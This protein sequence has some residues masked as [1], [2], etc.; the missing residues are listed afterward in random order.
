M[1]AQ[2]FAARLAKT[3]QEAKQVNA[4]LERL[5][6]ERSEAL[7]SGNAEK[8]VAS[9]RQAKALQERLEDLVITKTTL[10][11]KLRAYKQNEPEAAKLRDE[12]QAAWEE[13]RTMTAE[14]TKAQQNI[15]G[16]SFLQWEPCRVSIKI[17]VEAS[18][19]QREATYRNIRQCPGRL[20]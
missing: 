14:I 18:S 10:E 1:S 15:A 5:G 8:A 13:L 19:H 17:R 20:Q 11:A 4:Q 16:I 3:T 6:T 9:N 2:E 12:V 7:A